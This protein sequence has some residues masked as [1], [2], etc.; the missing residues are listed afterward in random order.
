MIK[1]YPYQQEAAA[2]LQQGFKKHKRQILCSPTG[3]GK[4]VIFSYI[5]RL[6]YEKGTTCLIVTDRI[7]LCKQNLA[8]IG[9]QG[10]NPQILSAGKKDF[11]SGAPVTVAMCETIK[12]RVKSGVISNYNPGLIIIDEAH[13]N[14]FNAIMDLFPR[15]FVVGA[16]ATPV[17]KTLHKYYN[18]IVNN[19][20]IPQL[21]E[22]GY[23]CKEQSFMMQDDFDDVKVVRGEYE[24][25]AL[26][27]HFDKT[28]LYD[29]VVREWSKKTPGL[30]TLVFN[31]NVEHSEKMSEQFN[32]AGISSRCV[33]SKT[34]QKERVKI[35]DDFR[36]G[37]FKVLCNCSILTTGYDDPSIQCIIVNR[38][39]MSLPLFLQMCGRGS[40]VH[41][42]KTRFVILDFGQNFMRHGLWS[43]E[44]TWSLDPPRKKKKGATPVKECPKCA[45]ILSAGASRCEFCNY[46]FPKSEMEIKQ[47]GI[48]VEVK[49]PPDLVGKKISQLSIPEL[50]RLEQSKK[51][52]PSFIWRVIRNRGAGAVDEYARLRGHKNGWA[53]RQKHDL[54]NSN[55][56]DYVIV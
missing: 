1:L 41:P 21:I 34:P 33:T 18:D 55:Y 15:A 49:P 24:N 47:G 14:S 9:N 17:S 37:K 54:E 12:R 28:V 53:F 52:K 29:G 39:T 8:H 23:L 5:V 20:D 40:R 11:Y 48:M 2:L 4:S 35:L 43:Q 32:K 46:F 25:K 3:S 19:I 10:I 44:R 13:K 7:E 31:V 26:Y 22:S 56:K 27:K 50:I 51:Y 6:A 16:T 30:K 45:A 42:S 36:K 38:A